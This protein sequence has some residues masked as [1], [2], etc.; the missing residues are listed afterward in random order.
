MKQNI[1][2]CVPNK[3]FACRSNVITLAGAAGSVGSEGSS[4]SNIFV[5]RFFD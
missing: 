1:S 4:L 5:E 3:Q 2:S